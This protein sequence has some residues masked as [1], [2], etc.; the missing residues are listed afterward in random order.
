MRKKN[1]RKAPEFK[2]PFIVLTRKKIAGWLVLIFF[3]CAW[4]F[5]LGILVGR[6]T[7]PVKFDL[8]SIE[9][10]IV[11]PQ[12][13]EP[14]KPDQ[15]RPQKDAAAVKDK[16]KLDFYEALKEDKEDTKVSVRPEPT[17]VERQAEDPADKAPEP[18][19][20][21]KEPEPSELPQQKTPPKKQDAVAQTNTAGPTYTLQAASVRNAGDADRLIQKLK[22]RGYP[23]Y[24]SMAKVPG[25]GTWFRVR[26]GSYKSKSEARATLDK[27]KKDGLKPIL[28]L[29]TAE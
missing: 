25:K 12:K 6:G 23:A 15:K 9:Q 3:V 21:T 20:K 7:A 10:K 28:V 22:K 29:R 26:V 2:K 14:I 18:L 8:A 1:K 24:R 19:K 27:L 13:A 11:A 4:M 5:V 17:P 16:T